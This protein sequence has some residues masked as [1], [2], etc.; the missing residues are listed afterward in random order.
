MKF[1][2]YKRR[3]VLLESI[4]NTNGTIQR[5][6]FTKIKNYFK[7]TSKSGIN[8]SIFRKTPLEILCGFTVFIINRRYCFG[9][10]KID[11]FISGLCQK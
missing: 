6:R 7:R 4:Q 5:K 1:L 8:F 3:I 9:F 11:G 10:S 2:F